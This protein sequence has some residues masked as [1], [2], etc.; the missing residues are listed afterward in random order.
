MKNIQTKYKLNFKT[1]KKGLL[2]L[3]AA[4]LVFVGCQNYDDQFDDLNAQ[5]SALKSQVDGL[6]SLSGQVA[7][8]SGSISGLQA[9]V[10]AAQASADAASAAASGIDL[11]GLAAGLATL[12]AEVDAVQASLATAATASAVAALQAELDAIEKDVDELLS[13]SNIY[14]TDI[15]VN[16]AST[17]DSALA[18]GNKVNILNASATIT[19]SAAMDQTKVQTLVNRLNTITGNLVFNSSSTTETTFENLTSVSDLTVGQKGGYNFKNLTSADDIVLNDLYETNVAVIDFRSLATVTTVTTLGESGEGFHFSNATELHL[20]KLARY[21]GDLTIVLKEGATLDMPILDDLGLTGLYE[22]TD[23]TLN[24]PASFTTTLMTD[25]TI[26]LTNVA[27]ANITGYRGDIEINTGV[28]TFTGTD[29]TEISVDSGADDLKTFTAKMKRDD[30]PTLSATQTA[31]LEHDAAGGNLGDIGLGGGLANLETVNISGKAGDITIS[32]APNLTSVA[33]SAD[34]FDLTMNDNDNLT[35]VDVTGAKFHDVS[36]TDMADLASLTLNHTTKLP[37]VDTTAANDE[38]GA[39]LTVTTNASLASLTVSA[40]DIDNLTV[41]T[42]ASLETVD[43]TGLTDDG[44]ATSTAVAIYN[45]SLDV[46]LVKDAYN[47]TTQNSAY[48]QYTATDTG[49]VTSD[50]GIGTLK[51]YLDNVIA[52]ASATAG[53]YVFVDQID[54]YEVQSNSINDPYTDTAV[55]AAPSVTTEAT[56]N[57]NKT[58]IY[59]IVAVQGSESAASTG[60]ARSETLTQTFPITNNA[61]YEAVTQLKANEGFAINV[62]GLS[63]SFM[64]GDTYAS[65]ANGSTVQTVADMISYINADTSWANTGVTITASNNGYLRSL[66]EVIYTDDEGG[67]QAVSSNGNIWFKLGSTSISGTV[68]VTA[69]EG[70]G[71]IAGPIATVIEAA[72]HPVH[73]HSMYNATANGAVIEIVQAVS[74]SGY[75]NDVTAG[76]SI[77]QVTFVIDAAQTSTTAQLG[78][79]DAEDINTYSGSTAD[80]TVSNAA[81]QGT[82]GGFNLY[83]DVHNVNGITFKLVNSS[84]TVARLALGSSVPVTHLPG[85]TSPT[86]GAIGQA[87]SVSQTKRTGFSTTAGKEFLFDTDSSGAESSSLIS[88]THFVVTAAGGVNNYATTFTEISSVTAGAVTQAAA[89]TDRTGWLSS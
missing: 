84:T 89:V 12:Q 24:G 70:A 87:G 45:N 53:V 80:A 23:L 35:S 7:S 18:L 83:T 2:T 22:N 15:T 64:M 31:A 25:G 46:Q 44:S 5:I 48:V 39:S 17:L 85:A 71:D 3:L 81:I 34:S 28:V 32:S 55:P 29:V 69:G 26:S 49:S 19:V 37:E 41:T 63:K 20:T 16:S 40:D 33:I 77:P 75:A 66:Q 79:G 86:I 58:S 38:K 36:I 11:T 62:A 43:F 47:D 82:T 78:E 13:T 51:T 76:A 10:A 88:G 59:A 8:L 27:T 56:A 42:N 4:S 14:A 1:M 67:A 61:I 68:A 72:T 54:K 74:V 21:P 30:E 6:A 57:S 73:G 50:S 65:A 60:Y 52:A 9:G